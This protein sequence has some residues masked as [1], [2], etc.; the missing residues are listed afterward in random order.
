M[1]IIWISPFVKDFYVLGGFN[2][3][4]YNCRQKNHQVC[5]KLNNWA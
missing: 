3:D 2:G 5:Q 1:Q 4:S